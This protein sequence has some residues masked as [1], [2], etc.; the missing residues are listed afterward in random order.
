MILSVV[1]LLSCGLI[2]PIGMVMADRELEAI[3]AGHRDPA[4]E[5]TAK[6]AKGIGAFG[7]TILTFVVLS[8]IALAT[9]GVVY[10]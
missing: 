9:I 3:A 8:A 6:I 5:R 4:N 2:S 10:A 7:T 1:G